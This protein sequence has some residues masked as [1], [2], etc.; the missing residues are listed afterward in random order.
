MGTELKN[1]GYRMDAKTY[2]ECAVGEDSLHTGYAR[3]NFLTY[4]SRLYSQIELKDGAAVLIINDAEEIL[5]VHSVRPAVGELS[6]ELPRGA[7]DGD[8]LPVEAAVRE[9][10]EETGF[11]VP[12]KSLLSLGFLNPANGILNS[13]LYLFLHKTSQRSTLTGFVPDGV[14]VKDVQWLNKYWVIEAIKNNVIT[15]A[16]TIALLGKAKLLGII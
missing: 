13:K 4:E 2:I 12:T 3:V 16:V 14:E 10:F 6:W 11:I 9:L 5:L 8:E 15:D 1:K 7:I